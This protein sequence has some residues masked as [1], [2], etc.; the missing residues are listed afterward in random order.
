MKPLSC[1]YSFFSSAL[2]LLGTFL[3]PDAVIAKQL[4]AAPKPLAISSQQLKKTIPIEQLIT[5][6]RKGHGEITIQS[7]R[8]THLDQ[9]QVFVIDFIDLGGELQRVIYDAITGKELDQVPMKDI[10]PIEKIIVKVL[11]R[12]K[13]AQIKSSRHSLQDGNQVVIIDLIDAKNKRWVITVDAHTGML[14][15]EYMYNL[16][17]KGRQLSLIHIIEKAREH[18]KGL[19]VLRTRQTI[20][21]NIPVRELTVRDQHNVRR[22]MIFNAQSGELLSNKPI[23]GYHY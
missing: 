8:Q 19:I 14:I 21:N 4:S 22:R 1:F 3:I 23:T 10:L 6:T 17:P 9:R 11:D 13:N 15:T 2:L 18:Q 5:Q 7:A 12:Y 20:F 16:K